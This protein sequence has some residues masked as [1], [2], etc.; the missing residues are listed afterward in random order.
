[1]KLLALPI[2]LMVSICSAQTVGDSRL[3]N[4]VSAKI[5]KCSSNPQ[6][7]QAAAEESCKDAGGT[8]Q[9]ISSHSN[10]GGLF[11]DAM[12]GPVTWYNMTYLCGQSDG[13][14]PE[15]AS[16]GPQ[17]MPPQSKRSAQPNRPI[18]TN[19]NQVGDTVSCTSY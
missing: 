7:C 4:G 12:P 16:R 9:V 13:A 14:P 19:C 8:Y 11:S 15:F 18:T 2:L 6:K 3:P 1:M 10:A 5:V 17:Y